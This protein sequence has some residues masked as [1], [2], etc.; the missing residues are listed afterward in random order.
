MVKE[1]YE[2][3]EEEESNQYYEKLSSQSPAVAFESVKFFKK[4]GKVKPQ[5]FLTPKA[6][7]ILSKFFGNDVDVTNVH[8]VDPPSTFVVPKPEP[9]P[10]KLAKTN[11]K[12]IVDLRKYC[13]P[14]GNQKQTG[15]CKAY[16]MTHG[17]EMLRIMAGKKHV[18]LSTNYTM[19]RTH[20]MLDTFTDFV[21][22]HMADDGTPSG[23]DPIT[24][25]VKTGVCSAKLW[26]NDDEEPTVS[27]EKMNKNA[28]KYK[29]NVK[30]TT[31]G[32]DDLKKL[33][34]K[35]IPIVFG[36]AT[37]PEFGSI[38]RD[39]IMRRAEEPSGK[40]GSHSMLIVGY[41][42]NYFIVKNSWGKEWGD[43]GYCYISK[44][45]FS[46]SNPNFHAYI[47]TKSFEE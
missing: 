47:P 36:M 18:E 15:R 1:G 17:I 6:F 32:I 35:G 19:V 14:I 34:S 31:V 45:I 37:G 23:L 44:Q 38:G 33:L 20:R 8:F 7:K 2:T 13:S 3:V 25:L 43:K 42:G 29:P 12:Q 11:P 39:G 9:L 40:H 30:P 10:K 26:P 5:G 21:T 4:G 41:V 16:S 27:E 22:A 46:K 24:N 28:K